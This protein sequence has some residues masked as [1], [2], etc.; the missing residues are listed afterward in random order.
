MLQL[1]SK[2]M[3]K[4]DGETLQRSKRDNDKAEKED[5]LETGGSET[6]G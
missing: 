3:N 2:E 6:E 1:L 4:L 5:E